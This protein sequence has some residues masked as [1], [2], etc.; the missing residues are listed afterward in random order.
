MEGNFEIDL[1]QNKKGANR[2]AKAPVLSRYMIVALLGSQ[3]VT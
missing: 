3:T 2:E 1:Q